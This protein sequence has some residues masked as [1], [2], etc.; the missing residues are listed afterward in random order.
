M[1]RISFLLLVF[2]W[3]LA[4]VEPYN[5][6][7]DLRKPILF[8]D[9][10]LTNQPQLNYVKLQESYSDVLG[11]TFSSFYNINNAE[12][13]IEIDGS[14]RKEVIFQ[15]R[16]KYVFPE[17]FK[18]EEGKTY[19]L[20][21]KLFDGRLFES[22]VQQ[23]KRAVP[24]KNIY[25]RYVSDAISTR[26]KK[27][28]G[29]KIFVDYDDPEEKGDFYYWSWR[30]FEKRE[31]CITCEGGSYVRNGPDDLGYCTEKALWGLFTYTDYYCDAPCWEIMPSNKISI[32]SDIHSNG[33]PVIAKE[34]L[35]V[36]HHTNSGAVIELRQHMIDKVAYEYLK[37][38]VDQSQNS[39]G[40]A[41]TPSSALIGNMKS[42]DGKSETISGYFLV[43]SVNIRNYFMTR[44]DIKN[45]GHPI[46]IEDRIPNP[47][48]SLI[49][50]L[51]PCVES[52]TRTGIEPETWITGG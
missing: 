40:F 43:S 42:S 19:R 44:L 21:I 27:V 9:A 16:G 7:L 8:V 4:C 13:W 23:L 38:I 36:S 15:R 25:Q 48:P 41:D 17:G 12:V 1:I 51:A 32:H 24:I 46:G 10:S 31:F 52:E 50:R 49:P 47:D 14:E 39:G 45:P 2:I 30:I 33:V 11:N 22:D 34:V 26:G 3:I 6:R 28:S 20:F 37:R 18:A 5:S 29:H 35:E